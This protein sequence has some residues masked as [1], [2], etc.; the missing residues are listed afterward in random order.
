M[1]GAG[2]LNHL[3]YQMDCI[4]RLLAPHVDEIASSENEQAALAFKVYQLINE[5]L[6]GILNTNW[7]SKASKLAIVG[8]IM[9]NCDGHGTDLFCPIKFEV[10]T[11]DQSFDI[12]P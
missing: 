7:M 8:G 10:R 12:F 1:G 11:L 2:D 3:D 4:K 5:F 6:E 9:V